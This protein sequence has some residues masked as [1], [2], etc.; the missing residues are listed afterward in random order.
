MLQYT[1]G[2]TILIS[3]IAYAPTEE[4]GSDLLSAVDQVCLVPYPADLTQLLESDWAVDT[5]VAAISARLLH[6]EQ[7]AL[8]TD[9]ACNAYRVLSFVGGPHYR[10]EDEEMIGVLMQAAAPGMR[11][12]GAARTALTRASSLFIGTLGEHASQWLLAPNAA[13]D[14]A[15]IVD[16]IERVRA[17]LSAKALHVVGSI[18]FDPEASVQVVSNHVTRIEGS[19]ADEIL[20]H[21]R[22]YEL[23]GQAMIVRLVNGM[24]HDDLPRYTGL[25]Q[26][27][28]AIAGH[29]LLSTLSPD[30]KGF[31]N[32]DESLLQAVSTARKLFMDRSVQDELEASP[33][34]LW[35]ICAR[36]DG[37]SV[38][39]RRAMLQAMLDNAAVS[40]DAEIIG[41]ATRAI[42]DTGFNPSEF[43]PKK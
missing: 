31:W 23:R 1:V 6:D 3:T 28:R 40:G 20:I 43:T 29:A 13:E 14:V 4:A 32:D 16:F 2:L 25:D 19:D 42:E 9:A 10:I 39:V 12:R 21:R 27:G 26:L 24:A 17:P 18:A 33:V 30:A 38:E 11:C 41:Y 37:L 34:G 5:L 7:Y 35:M 8:T 22:V 36:G 15:G